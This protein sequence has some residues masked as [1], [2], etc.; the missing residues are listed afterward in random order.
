M[1]DKDKRELILNELICQFSKLLADEV[2][3]NISSLSDTAEWGVGLEELCNM[4]YEYDVPVKAIQYQNIKELS[5]LMKMDNST[6]EMI[7]EL[8]I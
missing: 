4:I 8:V 7:E 2:I 3:E 5:K 1:I 6:H